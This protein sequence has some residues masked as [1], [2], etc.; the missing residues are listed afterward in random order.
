MS[1]DFSA[2]LIGLGCGLLVGWAS[3]IVI[4][5]TFGFFLGGRQ[6]GRLR[7]RIRELENRLQKKDDLIR[8]AVKAVKDSDQSSLR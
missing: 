4:E 5:R 6:E 8:K 2:F 3:A 1:G 7:R